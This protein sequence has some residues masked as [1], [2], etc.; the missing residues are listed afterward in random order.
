MVNGECAKCYS[1][2][3]CPTDR[4]GKKFLCLAETVV[5]EASTTIPFGGTPTREKKNILIF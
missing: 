3:R 5:A 2:G 1:P 4:N